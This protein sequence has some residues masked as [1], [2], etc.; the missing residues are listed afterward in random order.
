M[1]YLTLLSTTSETDLSI[2]NNELVK[3]ST[4]LPG[5]PEENYLGFKNRWYIG[6]KSG[7]SC[8]FR[9]LCS[10]SIELGFG[11][12]ED[13]YDEDANDIEATHQVIAL[14]RKLVESGEFVDC[15]DAWAHGQKEAEPLSGNIEVNLAAIKDSEFRFFEYYRF[16]F[17]NK[18]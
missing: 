13:W 2:N 4:E 5:I 12:P 1:C 8:D 10:G 16:T 18:S 9:H 11:E 3:F 6:S 14:I 17:S 15:I 7:C